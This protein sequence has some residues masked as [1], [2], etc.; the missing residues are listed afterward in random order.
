MTTRAYL[1]LEFVHP[2]FGR[3]RGEAGGLPA[4]ELGLRI[5]P[6]RQLSVVEDEAAVRQALLILLTTRPGERVMRPGYG[7]HLHSLAFAPNDDTTAG[8]AMH[9]VR[10]AIER[11]EPRVSISHIDAERAANDDSRLDVVVE[12]RLLAF[13]R[14]DR[15]VVPVPLSGREA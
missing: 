7:C 10:Q 12:Y 3:R 9:Y 14:A 2:D 13:N 4:E 6:Q 5:S 1:A 8:L 15:L 11:W